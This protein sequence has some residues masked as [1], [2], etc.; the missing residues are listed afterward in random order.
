MVTVAKTIMKTIKHAEKCF[1]IPTRNLETLGTFLWSKKPIERGMTRAT[2][3]DAIRLYGMVMFP[4]L[5]ISLPSVNV[6]KGIITV[7]RNMN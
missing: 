2:A 1:K 5:K 3:N 7:A 6:Q 4:S